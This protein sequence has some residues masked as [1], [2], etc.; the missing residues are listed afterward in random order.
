MAISMYG[1]SK[2]KTGGSINELLGKVSEIE[3]EQQGAYHFFSNLSRQEFNALALRMLWVAKHHQQN[4]AFLTAMAKDLVTDM[5]KK[6]KLTLNNFCDYPM[7]TNIDD[8]V[9]EPKTE[10]PAATNKYGRIKQQTALA[11]VK[12][13]EK[14]KTINY[15]LGDLK[16][17][18]AFVAFV[19]QRQNELEDDEVWGS[20][21]VPIARKLQTGKLLFMKPNYIFVKKEQCDEPKSIEGEKRLQNA[22]EQSVKQLKIEHDFLGDE[23]IGQYTAEQYNSYSLLYEWIGYIYRIEED[24]E[25][26]YAVD[27]ENIAP[28]CQY[29]VLASAIVQPRKTVNYAKVQDI[30]LSALCFY[31]SPAHIAKLFIARRNMQSYF[32]V[33]NL[34]NG[35]VLYS[36][37]DYKDRAH[38]TEGLTHAFM[39]DCLYDL[40]KG[41]KR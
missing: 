26:Y 11:K 35:Q 37:K 25:P 38:C 32:S 24:I 21:N 12:P 41:G 22:I 7:G 18:S 14:F 33:V 1:M 17:D 10:E 36:A 19:Q 3:S 29:L 5:L 2:H 34:Q 8:I 39:Y 40:K 13:S 9:D 20:I 15:M 4:N 6:F 28:N 23:K 27:I 16:Q 31:V 30:I